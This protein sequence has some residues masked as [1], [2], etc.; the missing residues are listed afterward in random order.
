MPSISDPLNYCYRLNVAKLDWSM[1]VHLSQ[2]WRFYCVW[3]RHLECNIWIFSAKINRTQRREPRK[4]EREREI[5][6]NNNKQMKHDR[7]VFSRFVYI[8]VT[9]AHASIRVLVNWS[10]SLLQV[11]CFVL[12]A[13]K[14]CQNAE[15][16]VAC[17]NT[18][19]C[20]ANTS[21]DYLK[22]P[23]QSDVVNIE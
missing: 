11:F 14:E 12:A 5:M 19:Q 10:N 1:F 3:L 8:M 21:F 13:W 20:H 15:L 2:L 22:L 9:S 23:Q 7:K 17:A 4:R 16:C 18:E 6:P